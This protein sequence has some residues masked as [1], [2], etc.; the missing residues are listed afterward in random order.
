MSY[1]DSSINLYETLRAKDRLWYEPESSE[2]TTS[3]YSLGLYFISYK[4]KC[5][6][7]LLKHILT[8]RVHREKSFRGTDNGKTYREH[9]EK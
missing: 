9:R 1:Q 3:L 2:D 6:H 4:H 7:F 5:K 8:R